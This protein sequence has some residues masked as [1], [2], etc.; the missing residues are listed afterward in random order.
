M[1]KIDLTN[2]K[3]IIKT[4]MSITTKLVIAQ[5]TIINGI[6]SF[7]IVNE[8]ANVWLEDMMKKLSSKTTS[9]STVKK[10]KKNKTAGDLKKRLK[11]VHKS[12]KKGLKRMDENME[13]MRCNEF[14]V[15]CESSTVYESNEELETKLAEVYISRFE[16]YGF[17]LDNLY[18][19]NEDDGVK[20][21]IIFKD[22]S[23]IKEPSKKKS[24][25]KKSTTSSDEGSE[26]KEMIEKE[27]KTKSK[28]LLRKSPSE[29][30]K[31]Y[32]EGYEMEGN[33]GKMYV[34]KKVVRKDGKEY[35]RWVKKKDGTKRKTTKRV[36][37]V[38]QVSDSEDETV[39]NEK[40]DKI[41]K[42][43]QRMLIKKCGDKWEIDYSDNHNNVIGVFFTGETRVDYNKD[44]LKRLVSKFMVKKFKDVKVEQVQ[45]MIEKN[46]RVGIDVRI[47]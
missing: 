26:K 19:R 3:T 41:S 27:T 8:D 17:E 31:D 10:S 45:V 30:P 4:N 38:Q 1:K 32:D 24:T 44:D 6:E 11:K 29:S 40:M 37:E 21:D 33:D 23:S 47:V 36:K 12:L 25:E 5:C 42:E 46:I 43:M 13:V 15:G 18:I 22:I 39:K 16:K 7:T 28:K 34:V 2:N 9:S 35:N 20:F 14:N